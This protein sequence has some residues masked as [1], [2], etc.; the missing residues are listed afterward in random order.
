[1]ATIDHLMDNAESDSRLFK[2]QEALRVNKAREDRIAWWREA[3]V[4]LFIHWGL[5]A[6]PGGV[7]NGE[8]VHAA[9]AEHL[10]LRARIPREE[11]ARI[12]ESFTASGFQAEAWVR[13]AKEAG[14][15]Y[16]IFTAKHHDGFA[17]YDSK[18]SDYNIVQATPFGRDPVAE[19]AEACR[20]ED[21]RLC[22]YYS[23]AMDWHHPDSQGNTLD[24]PG[25][26][27]A[28]DTLESWIHDSDKR[29][30]YER[31]LEEKAFPQLHEML[32]QYG[33]IGI[34]WFDCGHKVTDEQGRRFEDWVHDLQNT[35]LVNRRV[36]RS[37]FGDYENTGDNQLHVR[38]LERDWES[39]ATLNHSWGYN[40]TD[41]N[42]RSLK[43]VLH[44]M[45]NV[46]SMGGNYV[47]NVG[48]TGAGE[49]DPV[50]LERL[51]GIGRWLKVNGDSIYG[52]E[53]SPI[54]KTPWGRSTWKGQT[55]YLHIW[56]WPQQGRLFVPGLRNAIRRAY[57][58]ADPK[59]EELVCQVVN[60]EGDFAVHLPATPLDA[61]CTVVAVEF[62]GELQANP[63]PVVF[64]DGET[65]VFSVFDGELSGSALR[66]DTG[67]AGRDVVK[68]WHHVHDAIV[69]PVRLVTPGAYRLT[70]VYGAEESSAGG[71]FEVSAGNQS[72]IAE[73]RGTGGGYIFQ[74][75]DIGDLYFPEVG[76]YAVQ[77]KP[78]EISGEVLMQL[79]EIRITL[80]SG[81]GS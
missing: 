28:Y 74:S 65:T 21:V 3:K 46:V 41:Q 7:W 31:Y 69:W 44:D 38:Q 30:R 55:L 6:V 15:R 48:P 70:A 58:L 79:K 18:V 45:I 49:F 24:F 53:R 34:V 60:S 9:Y 4:G 11:Y 16:L 54:G 19:L 80:T 78:L 51:Q 2:Q 75:F 64:P 10:Q 39:I 57:L 50:S 71:T 36:R 52:T 27:G 25:N 14:L 73:V 5:Y 76:E 62:E 26:I 20:Q 23:H 13:A 56:T 63:C 47:I 59:R 40:Q 29:T 33:P 12:A 43:D 68:D 81:T 8:T 72:L 42:W 77:V 66:L 37:G 67:K 1:M 22:L 61:I 17:M 32:T 35:C